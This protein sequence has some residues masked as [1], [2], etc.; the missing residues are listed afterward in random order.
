M[1][2]IPFGKHKTTGVFFD[3]SS[4]PNGPKCECICKECGSLLEAVHPKLSNRQKYF[5]H[6]STLNCKGGLESLFHLVAK[7]I[8]KESKE[9]RV[10]EDEI[11]NY[12]DE[13]LKHPGMGNNRMLISVTMPDR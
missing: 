7:Q 9:L 12:V 2:K 10:S 11:Y 8:L 13:R 1:L 5:R 3:A 6:P 4:V